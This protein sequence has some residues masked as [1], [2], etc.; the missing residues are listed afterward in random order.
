MK[1]LTEEEQ[2]TY[3]GEVATELEEWCGGNVV[4]RLEEC[5]C[6]FKI[7]QY[8]YQLIFYT[9]MLPDFICTGVGIGIDMEAEEDMITFY[10]KK[11]H[12]K[13]LQAHTPLDLLRSQ[14]DITNMQPHEFGLIKLVHGLD[15][16]QLFIPSFMKPA[17][18]EYQNKVKR[19]LV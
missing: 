8:E 10:R 7:L 13:G 11:G 14:V 4:A 2:T 3:M 9:D 17:V 5:V 16:H 6:A 19:G 18:R 15:K 12:Y 1:G